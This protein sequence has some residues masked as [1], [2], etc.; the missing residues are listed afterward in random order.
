MAGAVTQFTP[1]ER[2]RQRARRAIQRGGLPFDEPRYTA[3]LKD[4]FAVAAPYAAHL[5]ARLEAAAPPADAIDFSLLDGIEVM[6]SFACTVAD[7]AYQLAAERPD[8]REDV[9][10]GVTA[11]VVASAIFDHACDE[12]RG[13]QALLGGQLTEQRLRLLLTAG[14]PTEQVAVAGPALLRYFWLLATDLVAVAVRLAGHRNDAETAILRERFAGA[15]VDSYR[16]ELAT[17]SAA[18]SPDGRGPNIWA[19]PLLVA[20]ALIQLA[21]DAP[22]TVDP[23]LEAVAKTVGT[24]FSLVDDVVDVE[25]DWASASHNR[26]LARA[27]LRRA[28]GGEL[29]WQDILAADVTEPYMDEIAA[30][31]ESCRGTAWEQDLAAWLYHWL[32][33]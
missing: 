3:Y 26:L 30:V 19:S 17:V 24:L 6:A 13:L 14:Q 11:Y 25:E 20:Y 1:S 12:D 33:A 5:R 9:R 21:R 7:I 32:Y 18:S 15:L 8:H 23:G 22:P 31:V 4:R 16:A 29:A 10:R 2:L 28:D 27:G